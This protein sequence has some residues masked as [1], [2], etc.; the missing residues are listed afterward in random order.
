[1]TDKRYVHGFS[2]A[3]QGRLTRMQALLNDAELRA[4][5]LCGVRS[6]LDV[7]S[8]LGQF[9]RALARAAG[10]GVRVVGVERDP[11]QLAEA[12]AQA[13]AAGEAGLVEFR[14]GD[15]ESLPLAAG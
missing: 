10:A 4:F 9:T 14:S 3:E 13:A 7:G 5:D 1:L 2:V 15:A 8:G 11:R 6:I 12:A